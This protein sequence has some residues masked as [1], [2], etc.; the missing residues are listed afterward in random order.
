MATVEDGA[1]LSTRNRVKVCSALS[2]S[3]YMETRRRR[4]RVPGT[5]N[6]EE[7]EK[8]EGC[9]SFRGRWGSSE[10]DLGGKIMF[11]VEAFPMK[12]KGNYY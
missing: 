1:P 2:H 8:E 6:R 10:V 11:Q 7:K 3:L 4:G 12:L 9:S 5:R